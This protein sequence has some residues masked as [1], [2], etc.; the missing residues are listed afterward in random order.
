MIVSTDPRADPCI[1]L[2]FSVLFSRS[3]AGSVHNVMHNELVFT[4]DESDRKWTL[5][6]TSHIILP[7]RALNKRALS[8]NSLASSS[9]SSVHM[10]LG[11]ILPLPPNP[12]P[13]RTA[14][15]YLPSIAHPLPFFPYTHTFHPP[16]IPSPVGDWGRYKAVLNSA[17][18]KIGMSLTRALLCFFATCWEGA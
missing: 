10:T 17:G 13:S 15:T 1:R 16:L 9:S 3:I 4:R 8:P 2:K 14:P 5:L 6:T 18:E 12:Y 7:H 11:L